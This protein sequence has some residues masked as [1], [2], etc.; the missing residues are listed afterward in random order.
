[1]NKTKV[2][3]TTNVKPHTTSTVTVSNHAL[4]KLQDADEYVISIARQQWTA[5]SP[6]DLVVR[7]TL[8]NPRL[9][10]DEAATLTTTYVVEFDME[11]A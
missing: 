11:P 5:L 2:S 7:F 4:S 9:T 6:I 3:C 1:M 8:V 10:I